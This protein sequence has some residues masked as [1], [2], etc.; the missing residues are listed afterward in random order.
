VTAGL[1]N[2]IQYKMIDLWSPYLYNSIHVH[3]YV[4]PGLFDNVQFKVIYGLRISVY[5]YR[6]RKSKYKN[7]RLFVKVN[8]EMTDFFTSRVGVEQGDAL[9]ILRD[10]LKIFFSRTIEPILTR[11]CTSYPWVKGIKFSQKKG[12]ALLHGEIIA[13]E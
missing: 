12:I 3:I 2:D 8:N 13:K 5:C 9:S 11:F 4:N 7:D 10:H 6:I 1:Y